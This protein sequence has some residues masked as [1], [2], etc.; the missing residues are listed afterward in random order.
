[1]AE[2]PRKSLALDTNLLLDLAE[3]K[4]F[5]HDFREEFAARG[6]SFFAP[7]TVLVELEM[8]S[9][10]GSKPQSHFANIALEG[11]LDWHTRPTR[12]TRNL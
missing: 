12:R 11:L 4:D 2:S 1:M 7:P 5:A 10:S 9:N 3:E 8:L 6:Y